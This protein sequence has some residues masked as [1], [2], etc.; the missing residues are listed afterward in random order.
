[1][2]RVTHAIEQ[3]ADCSISA[4]NQD[5]ELFDVL[6]KLEADNVIKTLKNQNRIKLHTCISNT[7]CY[8][9]NER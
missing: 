6:E 8:Y 7:F 4:T 3:P 1:M 5:S 2:F 9:G